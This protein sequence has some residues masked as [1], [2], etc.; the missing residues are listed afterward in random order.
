MI[1]LAELEDQG[2]AVV[3]IKAELNFTGCFVAEVHGWAVSLPDGDALDR[4]YVCEDGGVGDEQAGPELHRWPEWNR[5]TSNL[6][7]AVSAALWEV[8]KRPVV[9]A[10]LKH[11]HA[12]RFR[13]EALPRFVQAL[14]A[15]RQMEAV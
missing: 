8:A 1:T 10:Q 5:N 4:V 11:A 14:V 3:R 12:T 9:A 6:E 15:Q 13:P 2:C 7:A